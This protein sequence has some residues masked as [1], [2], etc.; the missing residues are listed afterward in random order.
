MK[1]QTRRNHFLSAAPS[2]ADNL[3]YRSEPP[4][5]ANCGLMHRG[6]TVSY[7]ITSSARCCSCK[8]TSRPSALWQSRQH[9]GGQGQPSATAGDHIEPSSQWYAT[10]S[11]SL[12]SMTIWFICVLSRSSSQSHLNQSIAKATNSREPFPPAIEPEGGMAEAGVLHRPSGIGASLG[13]PV[14]VPNTRG[15]AS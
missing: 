10:T 3:L 4:G 11:P 6:K 12:P 7:S 2:I 5:S 13:Q 9:G 15:L 8:G 1:G 14:R